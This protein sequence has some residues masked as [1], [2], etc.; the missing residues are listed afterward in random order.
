MSLVQV[1][2]KNFKGQ[3]QRTSHVLPAIQFQCQGLEDF[4]RQLWSVY[5]EYIKGT[6]IIPFDDSI[7]CIASTDPPSISDIHRYFQFEHG[8]K[9]ISN[10]IVSLEVASRQ[11]LCKLGHASL[12]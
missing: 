6:A 7:A 11:L 8:R 2:V 3:Q 12:T 4:K 1:T 10:L 9:V 5:H